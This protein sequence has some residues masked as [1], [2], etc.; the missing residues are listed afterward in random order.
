MDDQGRRSLHLIATTNQGGEEQGRKKGN[1][2]YE[3]AGRD[4]PE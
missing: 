4:G 3:H 1:I 2:L